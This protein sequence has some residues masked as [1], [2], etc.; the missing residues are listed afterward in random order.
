MAV[1]PTDLKFYESLDT[2]SLGGGISTFVVP[3]GLNLF[4]DDVDFDEALTGSTSYRCFYVKNENL[5]DT[6]TGAAIYIAVRTPSPSTSCE[7]GLG[8]SGLNGTEQS[9][10]AEEIAPVG[11]N[12]FATSEGSPLAI[13]DLGPN[14][15]YPVWIK[16]I[17]APEAAGASNDYV[18]IGLTG[19]GGP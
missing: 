16:R 1:L 3:T 18:V 12:F 14:E 13:G 17:V 5:S 10:T 2:S 4:Y 15:Y 6:Y 8:T 7:L 11:V 9:I 19:D